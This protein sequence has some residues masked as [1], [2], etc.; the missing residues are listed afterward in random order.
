M[1][2]LAFFNSQRSDKLIFF[3]KLS[4]RYTVY[5]LRISIVGNSQKQLAGSFD[6]YLMTSDG[7]H[8]SIKQQKHS[9]RQSFMR[10]D[11]RLVTTCAALYITL[12]SSQSWNSKHYLLCL[13]IVVSGRFVAKYTTTDELRRLSLIK[14]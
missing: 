7:H 4:L 10:Y 13:S 6:P 12:W 9:N 11:R 3:R 2:S 8:L 5:A 14:I 1:I